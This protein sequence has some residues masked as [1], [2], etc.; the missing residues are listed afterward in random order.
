MT[1][2]PNC[3]TNCRNFYDK[4]HSNIAFRNHSEAFKL[5]PPPRQGVVSELQREEDERYREVAKGGLAARAQKAKDTASPL[6][7]TPQEER[8]VEEAARRAQE[9]EIERQ[10]IP[11]SLLQA[12]VLPRAC[13]NELLKPVKANKDM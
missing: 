7:V 1:A 2:N 11:I 6:S 8:R 5:I 9:K 13:L 3:C 4:H 10:R 12:G